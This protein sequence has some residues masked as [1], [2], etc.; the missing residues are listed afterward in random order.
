MSYLVS[1]DDF[2]AKRGGRAQ[3]EQ[4]K[5]IL[6]LNSIALQQFALDISSQENFEI[7][8]GEEPEEQENK[9]FSCSTR[10][11]PPLKA[12]LSLG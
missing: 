1:R 9:R 3:E 2:E 11:L 6:S 7:K 4:G 8:K 10:A 12:A 5:T